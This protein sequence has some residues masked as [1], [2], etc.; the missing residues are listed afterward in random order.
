MILYGASGHGKVVRSALENNVELFFDDNKK[1]KTFV[2]VDVKNYDPLFLK[3]MSLII[4]IGNNKIRKQ[5]SKK[6]QHSYGIVKAK[7]SIVDKSVEIGEGSQIIHGAVIQMDVRI[8]SHVIVNTASS[9][10]HDCI[11]EDF[12]HIAPNS[13]L[14]G[15]VF[16]GEGTLI[17]A[18][19]IVL[20][21]VKIGAWCKIGAGGVIRKDVPDHAIVIG[22]PSKRIK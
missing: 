19:A 21:G 20:P 16:I 6:I 22:N 17:G 15:N 2:G 13:T 8:G 5:V 14:C 7:S 1:L 3:E 9:I 18:G 11:I 4:S 10:D 12:V